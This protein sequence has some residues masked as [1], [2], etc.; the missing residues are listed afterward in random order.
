MKLYLNERPR[1]FI[2]ASESHAL[3]VRYPFPKY[4][5]APNGSH[6]QHHHHHLGY[7][8][9]TSPTDSGSSSKGNMGPA[10]NKVLVEFVRKESLQLAKFRDITPSKSSGKLI[11]GFLGF[12]SVKS[13]I[14]LGFITNHNKSATPVVG[15][16]VYTITGVEFYCLT[17]DEYDHMID[18]SSFGGSGSNGGYGN[19][20]GSANQ[21]QSSLSDSKDKKSSDYPAA[22]I[23]KFLSS[24]SFFYSRDFDITSHMQERGYN[25][26]SP[27]STRQFNLIADSP[28]FKRFQWNSFMNAE[29]IEFRNRLSPFERKE[30]D[31]T[32]FLTTIARGY[33]QTLN[34][35]IH[36]GVDALLTVISKQSCLKNGPLFGDWGCDDS[37]EASNFVE[38]EVI[39]YTARYC[40]AYVIVRGNVPIFWELE[41]N[42]SKKN[43]LSSKKSK[44][45]SYPRSFEASQHA[46][47]RHFEKL[48]NQY[49][50][51]HI[52]NALSTDEK[53]YKGDLNQKFKEHLQYF[54]THGRGNNASVTADT[55][56]AGSNN[57]GPVST[58]ILCT[59]SPV[60]TSIVKK[61]GYNA[62]NPSDIVRMLVQGIIDYG[63]YFYDIQKDSLTGKQLGVFRVNSF[64]CLSKANF[65][66]KI[67]CQEVIQLALRDVGVEVDHDLLVKH[68]KLWATNDEIISKLTLNFVSNTTK[69]QRSSGATTKGSIKSHLTKKYLNSV[70]EPKPNEMAMLKLLGRL[71]DQVSITLK[72]PIHDYISSE[73]K[74]RSK[75]FSSHKDISIFASTF[76]V[77]G[78]CTE[79]NVDGWLYPEIDPALSYDVVFIGFQE[80]VELTPGHMVNTNSI[81]RVWWV[82][83]IKATLEKN[84][85]D[86]SKYVSLWDG[87]LGGIALLLYI[88]ESE[89]ENITNVEGSFKKTGLGGMSANKGGV[90]VSFNYYNTQI[91]LVAAHLAA[92][93]S[94]MDERH[95]NYKTIAK[96][97]KF[98]KN[99]RIRDH[100]AVIWLGDF[101]YRI[102][103]PNEQVKPLI[104]KEEYGKLFEYDQLNQ[105]MAIGE[106][107]PFFDEMEIKFAPTY[108]FDNGTKTYDTSEKQ[109]IPA[110]TDR[111]LS[112]S[113][114]KLVK[115][116]AYD[117]AAELLFSDHRPVYAVFK[118][119]VHIVD[120][121]KKLSLSNALYDT[122]KKNFGGINNLFFSH[123]VSFL[124]GDDDDEGNLPP[125]SSEVYKWWIHGGKPAKV[126]IKELER[127]VKDGGE[128]NV[129][130]PKLPINPFET[131]EEPEFVTNEEL[132]NILQK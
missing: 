37:G 8:S 111:I 14:Y 63:A 115:Q 5:S 128:F 103:L 70:V 74:D 57:L 85:P 97:I 7:H 73:L 68:G 71:Q 88:K 93:L 125:P 65:L 109:R 62:T 12:I 75:E 91:C 92:G 84:S 6:S 94:N 25:Q 60:S 45:I 38:T 104:E 127:S 10:A 76:N 95:Q 33:A 21:S 83:Q 43:I 98:S 1:T 22:S 96:G 122:Y 24:G 124:M 30:F 52:V 81:N 51:V 32:G 102:G 100:D 126:Y 3:I 120:E 101:N 17:S 131:T 13:N 64:D 4:K 80:I 50:E 78:C 23:R 20:T 69:L 67:I 35:V 28:Y 123:D 39:I 53:S 11:T 114:N 106:S 41:S 107:F 54:N 26:K 34:A 130:N 59:D 58:K 61:F 72:N 46:F 89:L 16:D 86:N 90:S 82:K 15:E 116:V 19:N 87:Q 27:T 66:S 79:D 112:M 48:S 108:K 2:L 42:L 129:I 55:T 113:R 29:L 56:A 117:S 132:A 31:K 105:Q 77:N 18:D 118:V 47:D 44:K 9:S 99:R 36:E 121:S 110:W 40:F 119:M 49:G